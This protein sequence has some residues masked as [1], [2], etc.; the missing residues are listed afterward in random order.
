[1]ILSKK[2]KIKLNNSTKDHF[3]NLGYNFEKGK[4]IEIPLEHLNK[5]SN[6]KVEVK[7]DRCGKIKEIPYRKYLINISNGNYYSCSAKCSKD[8]IEQS[9][10]KKFGTK[11]Y[12]QSEEGK[13]KI[14]NIIIEKFGVDNISK[15][16][17][18]K[19][20][21][22]ETKEKSDFLKYKEF[23]LTKNLN[24]VK[25][26]KNQKT[27]TFFCKKCK[28]EYTISYNLL[29]NRR[30]SK[31]K[32]CTFCNPI[33]KNIS[34]LEIELVNFIRENYYGK[35]LENRKIINPYELDIYL[36]DLKL[37]FEFNGLYWHNELN[38]PNNYHRM[39]SDL[40]IE[41]GI[42]LIHI[43]ED[44][45]LNK[46][47]IVKSIILDK[48]GKTKILSNNFLIKEI[49]DDSIVKHFLEEN[50]I[51]GYTKSQ[52]KIG[53]FFREKLFSLMCFKKVKNDYEI[54]RFCDEI[55]N[56]INGSEYKLLNYFIEN[57]NVKEIIMKIDRSYSAGN[58]YKKLGFKEIEK[59]NEDY[60]YI[61]NKKRFDK[62][63][64]Q[65]TNTSIE[66]EFL[67][68]QGIYKIYDAGYLTYKL[69]L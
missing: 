16:E 39:K 36:P 43:W 18:I 12:F 17:N 65:K 54:I 51:K 5:G 35:I 34:G 15:L 41:K 7:C 59:I 56:S 8:K 55:Y 68:N 33:N 57:H 58:L 60:Y 61:E 45:W 20:K 32:I 37:A 10:I 2:I 24:L 47:E 13:L 69:T 3:E 23:Y 14:K 25:C 52:I 38:K 62:K 30:Y 22:L 31:T 50:H 46:K 64:F 40:C 44:E 21:K 4:E 26:D 29:K 67:F 42:Q 53:L 27:Y 6:Y 49:K 48:L 19:Q 66:Q 28:K 63:L 1:M 9:N 11:N